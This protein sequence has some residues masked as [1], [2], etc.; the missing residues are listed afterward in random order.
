MTHLDEN[1]REYNW[2]KVD[3]QYERIFTQQNTADIK[4]AVKEG[5]K[6]IYQSDRDNAR[7]KKQGKSD[8]RNVV[9]PTDKEFRGVEY[10]FKSGYYFNPRGEYTVTVKT[11]QY[12][13]SADDTDEHRELI[14]KLKNAFYYKSDLLYTRDG[15]NGQ[16]LYITNQNSDVFGIDMLDIQTNTD[17]DVEILEH[18]T[19]TDGETHRFFKEI[20]EGYS[21]SNTLDSKTNFKYREY[22][23]SGNIYKVTETTVITF[24]VASSAGQKLYTFANMKNGNYLINVGVNRFSLDNYRYAGLNVNKVDSLEN[25]TVKVKG[26]MYDD[27]NN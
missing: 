27:L 18:T 22:I 21:E 25:I 20:L 19:D 16:S 24:K 5:M 7:E 2:T 11:V 3:G 1:D 14:D 12:K 9:F 23:K 17:K 26:S 13:N 6:D 8:Y 15:R 10:P 4:W